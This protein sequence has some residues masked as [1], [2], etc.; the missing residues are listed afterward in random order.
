MEKNTKT[1]KRQQQQKL[2]YMEARIQAP[3]TENRTYYNKNY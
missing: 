2:G 3:L 1:K